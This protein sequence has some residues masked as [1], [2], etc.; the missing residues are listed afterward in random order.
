MVHSFT[1]SLIALTISTEFVFD[2]RLLP[3]A[4]RARLVL[5]APTSQVRVLPAASLV[6][7]GKPRPPLAL[8]LPLPVKTATLALTALRALQLALIVPLGNTPAF[9]PL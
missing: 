6:V 3:V 5:R 8:L 9:R 7:A 2:K 4:Q 1:V